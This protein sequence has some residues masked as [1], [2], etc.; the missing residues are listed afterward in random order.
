MKGDRE[1]CLA[2]GMDA[3]LAKPIHARE[4]LE[5]IDSTVPP[6][7]PA[8]SGGQPSA[9]PVDWALALQS[10]GGDKEILRELAGLFL[11]LCPDWLAQLREVVV[12]RDP[13]GLRRL[14]HTIKG[15]L[16]QLGAAAGCAAALRL[17]TM[18]REGDLTEVEDCLRTLEEELGRV[19]P[20]LARWSERGC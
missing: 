17:E 20:A 15:S 16:G 14:A 3:Y 1:R 9:E 11:S 2:A 10:V 12:R 4:L 18:G 19:R 8:S 6:L 7:R 13:T 5:V